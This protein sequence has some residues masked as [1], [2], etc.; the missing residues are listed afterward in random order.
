MAATPTGEI[1]AFCTIWFDDATRSA[2]C[3]LVGTAPEHRRR[4]LGKAVM[5]EGLG[6]L[7]KMGA[8]RAFANAYDPPADRLYGS[9]LGRKAL[10]QP[11]A[12][13]F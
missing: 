1:A 4:G 6:R 2:V 3:V 7:K 9:V 5:G 12:K 10:S 11:W 13:E 8:T